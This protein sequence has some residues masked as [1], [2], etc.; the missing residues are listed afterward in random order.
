VPPPS[1]ALRGSAQW[2][3]ATKAAGAGGPTLATVILTNEIALIVVAVGFGSRRLFF[4]ATPD[5]QEPSALRLAI[6]GLIF[7]VGIM[8]VA[9]VSTLTMR[10]AGVSWQA[11]AIAA[12]YSQGQLVIV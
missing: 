2:D 9:S 4:Y 10:A 8:L 5:L 7:I 3:R 12:V 11:A 1:L 6:I